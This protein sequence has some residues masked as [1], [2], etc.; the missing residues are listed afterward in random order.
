MG[1][2]VGGGVVEEDC[3]TSS[4]ETTLRRS[5]KRKRKSVSLWESGGRKAKGEG[6]ASFLMVLLPRG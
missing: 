6:E 1:L 5:N 4:S 3:V 2:E